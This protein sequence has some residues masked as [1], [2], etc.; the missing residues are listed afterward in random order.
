[1]LFVQQGGEQGIN[2]GGNEQWQSQEQKL[3][4]VKWG[5]EKKRRRK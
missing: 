4:A 1:V 2:A 5:R 3:I